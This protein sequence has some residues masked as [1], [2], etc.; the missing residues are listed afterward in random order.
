VFDDWIARMRT[1]AERVTAIRSLFDSAPEEARTYFAV[2]ADHSF[3]IDGAMFETM[4]V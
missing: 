4:K 3:F 2:E 1:P